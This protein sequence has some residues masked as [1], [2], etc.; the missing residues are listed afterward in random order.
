MSLKIDSWICNCIYVWECAYLYM[1]LV[2]IHEHI[3]IH[4]LLSVIYSWYKEW[5][6]NRRKNTEKNAESR[7][8]WW[9]IQTINLSGPIIALEANSLD[10]QWDSFY[11]RL[12]KVAQPTLNVGSTTPWIMVLGKKVSWVLTTLSAL[13]LDT[14]WIEASCLPCRDWL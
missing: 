9:S 14:M 6:Y 3:S 4:H 11:I 13:W 1:Y 8:M 2:S 10:C 5:K 12:T 7:V